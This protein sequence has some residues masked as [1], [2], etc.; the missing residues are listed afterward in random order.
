MAAGKHSSAAGP[1]ATPIP[2]RT[3][4]SRRS[5]RLY[6]RARPSYPADAVTKVLANLP[7]KDATVLELGAGTGIFSR[8]ILARAREA[9]VARLVA[10]EPSEGMR[11][12]WQDA[13]DA[14]PEL[15]TVPA[16][17]ADGLFQATGQADG[18][19]DVVAVAQAWH[20]NYREG[21]KALEEVARVLKPKGHLSLIWNLEDGDVPVSRA[22]G[23]LDP[24]LRC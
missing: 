13:L 15:K 4:P 10:L 23:R 18:S 5:R 16:T 21:P 12:G 9:G 14:R 22:P 3:D 1:S 2:S 20:W 8:L 17:I 24:G 19:A 11:K 6:D 7:T